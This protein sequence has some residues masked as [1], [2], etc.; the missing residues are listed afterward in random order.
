MGVILSSRGC[1]FRCSYCFHMWDRK[2]RYRS[3]ESVI[4]I[5]PLGV[6]LER[7]QIG[8]A[9]LGGD[10]YLQADL[11]AIEDAGHVRRDDGIHARRLRGIQRSVGLLQLFSVE[12]DVQR[13]V[14]LDAIGTADAHNLRKVFLSEI[15]GRMRTHV[16]MADAEIDR[17]GSS[18]DGGHQASEIAGRR[19]NLQFLSV[20]GAKLALFRIFV[21]QRLHHDSREEV[22]PGR[23]GPVL[24]D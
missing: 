15:V 1:P 12:G 14:G 23:Q 13:H 11:P 7:L 10:V 6:E 19:H 3:V 22:G 24:P 17:V 4:H 8:D 16:Q 5:G 9:E 2:V 20:H 21:N 18:L